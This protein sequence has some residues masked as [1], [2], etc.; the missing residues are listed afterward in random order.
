MSRNALRDGY[1]TSA[2]ASHSPL[3]PISDCAT[4][5]MNKTRAPIFSRIFVTWRP[6]SPYAA[7]PPPGLNL[8]RF[9]ITILPVCGALASALRTSG[10]GTRE[11]IDDLPDEFLQRSCQGTLVRCVVT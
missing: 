2:I 10:V 3:C 5:P 6:Y 8:S 7:A 4:G 1:S 11:L 9:N